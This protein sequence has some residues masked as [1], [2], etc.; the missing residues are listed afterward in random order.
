[1]LRSGQVVSD[2][3]FDEI[4]PDVVRRVSAF[5]WT[6]IRVCARVVALL[7]L[8]PHTRV[9]DI[10][11]GVGKF[12]IVASAMSGGA[13]IRGIEKRSRL[14]DTA[15]EAARRLGVKVEIATDRFGYVDARQ[16]D[17]VYLFNPFAEEILLPG[18]GE[19]SN[20]TT[21]PTDEDIITTQYFL[22]SARI[23]TRAVTYCG[24][25]GE[26]PPSYARL[27]V[28]NWNGGCLELWEKHR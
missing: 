25:G 1:M 6:P 2:E 9:L 18:L 28:E 4:Y 8:K 10:G 17:A 11:A 20:D 16:I 27:A 7:G 5:H 12:C 14:A 3:A 22:S 13:K 15:R 26:V 21:T 23:G 24:F 19:E